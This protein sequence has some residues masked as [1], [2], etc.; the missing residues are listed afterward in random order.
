MTIKKDLLNIKPEKKEEPAQIEKQKDDIKNELIARI[1]ILE[2][3][4]ALLAGFEQ[5][6]LKALNEEIDLLTEASTVT[7]NAQQKST[8]NN[9][10][11]SYKRVIERWDEGASFVIDRKK[12][13]I[14]RI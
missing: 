9:I 6:L 5:T 11:S 2:K 1:E 3:Q 4:V 10:K 14:E 13:S 7:Q 8:F 12:M